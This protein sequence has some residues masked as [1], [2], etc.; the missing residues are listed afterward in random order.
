MSGD[1]TIST[2]SPFRNIMTSSGTGMFQVVVNAGTELNNPTLGKL[3]ITT[4]GNSVPQLANNTMVH[5]LEVNGSTR[6]NGTLSIA[7][8]NGTVAGADNGTIVL[9]HENAGG[10]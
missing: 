2:S 3:F 4:V 9:D 1:G 5:H 10:V 7:E 8:P 6:L